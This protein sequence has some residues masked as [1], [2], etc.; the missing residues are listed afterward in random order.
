M[1]TKR[2]LAKAALAGFGLAALSALTAAVAGFGHRFGLW[3]FSTG[4][5]ILR[6]AAYGALASLAIS[7]AGLY[8][9]RMHKQFRGAVWALIGIAI[10]LAAVTP[11]LMWL[12]TARTVPR[13]HDITTDTEHP[14]VFVAILPLRREAP[15]PA[16]YGGPEIAAL[17]HAGYPELKPALLAVSPAQAFEN[18]LAVARRMGWEVVGTEPQ[19]GRIEATATTFWFGFKDDVVIRIAPYDHGSRV[20]A[21]SVSRVGLSDVGT[22]AKRIAEFMAALQKRVGAPLLPGGTGPS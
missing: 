6:W 17:Q 11:P 14:P 5:V 4:F 12:K 16:E 21:R 9:A 19:E 18:S 20:D 1:D 7:L 8:I 22:N 10:A 3:H 13:I 15:N 2:P